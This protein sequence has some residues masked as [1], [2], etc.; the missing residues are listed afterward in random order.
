M[1]ASRRAILGIVAISAGLRLL[2]AAA[3]GPSPDEAYYAL[4]AEHPAWSYFDHPPM[5]AV[6]AGM[7]RAMGGPGSAIALRIGFIALFAGST[8]LM[9]R[10]AG[11]MFGSG[12]GVLAAFALNVAGYFGAIVGTC[13]LPDGP[14]VFFWLLTL[15]RIEAALAAGPG[16]LGPWIGVG[17]AWGGTLLSKY[18]AVFLP[19]GLGLYLVLDPTARHW[20]RRPGPYLALAVGAIAFGPVL[21][22]N[23]A[24]GWASFAFQ[25]GRALAGDRPTFRL[26]TLA[27]A[28]A[29]Q[30]AY[31]LPWIWAGLLASAWRGVRS[32][33]WSDPSP[34]LAAERRL[35]CQ[36]A[37]P[38]AAFGAIACVREVLPHWSLVGYLPLIPLL[39]RRWADRLAANPIRMRR[40]LVALAAL[41][42]AVA[43]LA[44]IQARTGLLQKGGRGTLGLL[45]TA[46]DPTLDLFGW[47]QVAEGLR[48]RGLVG[49]PG[50]FLFTGN[51]YQSGQLAFAVRHE[52]PVLCYHARDARGFAYWSRPEAWVGRDGIFVGID[53]RS[54]EPAC[55]DRWFDRIEPLGEFP[56]VRA[57]A[58]VHT[59]RLFRCSGQ[60]R[61]FPF[62][63]GPGRGPEI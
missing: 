58:V 62:A 43:G 13:A 49:R 15:E 41:P 53:R 39:G 46:S 56:I 61:P 21:G 30:A 40:R 9:A 27:G 36:A 37:G 7:G 32:W 31:L 42:I 33:S 45:A 60:R 12:A 47:D 50:T 4:F 48:S 10:L 52:A 20:L 16:R 26:D 63:P 57:G 6:V 11:R 22:W 55:F 3:L 38:L 59:V 17:L 54:A 14:L 2:L 28:I 23:A 18:H 5:I 35:I 24:H 1:T 8:L 29:G 34:T 19:A 51:W 44:S 25:G